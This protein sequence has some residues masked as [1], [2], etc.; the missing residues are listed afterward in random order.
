MKL[1]DKR[2]NVI[3]NIVLVIFSIKSFWNSLVIFSYV[4]LLSVNQLDLGYNIAWTFIDFIFDASVI[5]IIINLK[6]YINKT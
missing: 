2:Y 4:I 1:N 3:L 6:K 5:G